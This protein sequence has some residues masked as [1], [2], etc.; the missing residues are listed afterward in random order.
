MG[1][2]GGGTEQAGRRRSR[3]W[4]LALLVGL[5]L[6]G[7]VLARRAQRPPESPPGGASLPPVKA[8]RAVAR[9]ETRPT[10]DPALFLGK[11]ALG[12]AAT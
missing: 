11:A 9:R 10:L 12:H 5:G 2:R 4:R 8:V 6:G 3:F 7:A 1:K